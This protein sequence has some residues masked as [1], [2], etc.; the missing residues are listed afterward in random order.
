L[1]EHVH[2]E[3][4]QALPD[5]AHARRRKLEARETCSYNGVPHF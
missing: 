1:E 3:I 5:F 4:L 2:G